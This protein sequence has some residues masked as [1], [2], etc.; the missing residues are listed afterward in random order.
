MSSNFD[1]NDPLDRHERAVKAGRA[2]QA[3][4]R[5]QSRQND[6]AAH[7]EEVVARSPELT[8]TQLTALRAILAPAVEKVTDQRAEAKAS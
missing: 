8:Q 7:V 3:K 5:Q 6:L 1:L 4:R 2:M